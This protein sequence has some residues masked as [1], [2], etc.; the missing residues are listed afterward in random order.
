MG[1]ALCL[2]RKKERRKTPPPTASDPRPPT[3]PLGV[4]KFPGRKFC[5]R[6][7]F[8]AHFWYPNPWIS[9]QPPPPPS[10]THLC[11]AQRGS[12]ANWLLSWQ[13]AASI[14]LW[15][16]WKIS[17]RPFF[18]KAYLTKI[19]QATV[20]AHRFRFSV[21]AGRGTNT[22]RLQTAIILSVEGKTAVRS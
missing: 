17:T 10:K 1:T 13:L 18:A 7:R 5:K 19:H 22:L 2:N 15:P 20:L 21:V 8:L 3:P 11:A 9:D 12:P 4:K 16:I 6:E 14:D